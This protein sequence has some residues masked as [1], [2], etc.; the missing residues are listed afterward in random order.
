MPEFPDVLTHG[1]GVRMTLD[2]TRLL[3]STKKPVD[4]GAMTT[5]A[6]ARDLVIERDASSVPT[7]RRRGDKTREGEVINHTNTRYWV[8]NQAGAPVSDAQVDALSRDLGNNLEWVGPVYQIPNVP[9]RGGLVCPLPNVLLVGGA[10]R[11]L[12]PRAERSLRKAITDAGL[13]EV[14]E[15]SKYLPG[16]RYY[17]VKDTAKSNAYEIRDALLAAGGRGLDVRLETMPMVKPIAVNPN[18]T[19]YASQWDMTQIRAG[20]AGT[21]GWDLETGLNTMVVAILDEGIDRN[22]PDLV[23]TAAGVNLGTMSGDGSPTGDHGTA[24]AGIAAAVFNNNAGIAGVAGTCQVMP[25]AFQ[26]WTDAECAAGITYAAANGASVISMSFGVYAPGDGMGPTGWDFAIIDPAITAAVDTEGLVLCAATGNEDYG[27]INRY[28]ARNE[29]VV[30][31]GASDQADNRKNPA[32]PDG[33]FWWGSNFGPGMDV[34]AP[35]VLI[36]TTDRLGNDGYDPGDYVM[37][38]NGTSAATPHVAGFAALLLSEFPTLTNQ[39]VRDAIERT[40]AKVGTTPY[41]DN[42]AMPNGVSND[43]MGYG[44][45]DVYQ[46]LDFADISINDWWGDTG[47]EPSSPPGGNFWTYSDIVV[48][49]QDDGIFQPDDPSKSSNIE[50]GQTNYLYVRVTNRGPA[51]ARNVVIGSRIVAYVGTQFVYPFDWTATDA[52][53]I[54]PT[55]ITASFAN[56]PVGGTEIAKFS[57]SSTQV[58]DVWGW[59]SGNSWHPCIVASATADNDYAFASASTTGGG[60]ITRRNNLA[61]RNVSVIDVLASA[62]VTFPFIIGTRAEFEH[63]FLEVQID[64]SHIPRDVMVELLIDENLEHVLPRIVPEIRREAFHFDE[65]LIDRESFRFLDPVR[66]ELGTAAGRGLLMMEAGSRLATT[67]GTATER[68]TVRG[69]NELIRDER[70]FV[71]IED[72]IGRVRFDRDINQQKA[73]ALQMTIPAAAKAGDT[74]PLTVSQTDPQGNII[75]GATV[76]YRVREG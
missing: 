20:G 13:T 10:T 67:N 47:T 52:Q 54:A 12:D 15:K 68:L 64:R 53:H 3:V 73:V 61:Q 6:N 74:F 56:I 66:V 22:H 2:P 72:S 28:P 65:V 40:A 8:H 60:L 37:D 16:Y 18:D 39:E 35:G 30:A 17:E 32:S 21:T 34:M 71:R 55:P 48:R 50:R 5:T 49:I 69:G 38:F 24:C 4:S 43:Q 11:R 75:G 51:A 45:I 25:I 36:P 42:P 14:E 76:I 70:R 41:V 1:T 26:N 63:E 31:V 29:R 57:I 9:G 23:C 59:I 46:G 33:E 62:T 7:T 19:L 27:V 44:R 58:E